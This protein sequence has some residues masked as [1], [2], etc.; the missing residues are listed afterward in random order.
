MTCYRTSDNF[1]VYF[2]FRSVE[3]TLEASRELNRTN[4]APLPAQKAQQTESSSKH[5]T[6]DTNMLG[7]PLV[8]AD[9]IIRFGRHSGDVRLR[10]CLGL[11]S[12]SKSEKIATKSRVS[13]NAWSNT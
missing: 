13:D 12:R 3:E 10:R 4:S 7:R 5:I 9:Q 2:K 11:S 1:I 6:F 8:S